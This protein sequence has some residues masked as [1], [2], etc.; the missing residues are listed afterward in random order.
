MN[1]VLVL[2]LA[3]TFFGFALSGLPLLTN[4]LGGGTWA[5]AG[6][7]GGY[8]LFAA[9][10]FAYYGGTALLVNTAWRR[11]VLPIGGQV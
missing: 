8:F 7:I 1:I 10:A 6:Q 2:V 11:V 5:R 9:G 4:Q 3:S